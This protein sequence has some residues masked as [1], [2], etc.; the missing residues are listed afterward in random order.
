MDSAQLMKMNRRSGGS[1]ASNSSGF[2]L[3]DNDHNHNFDTISSVSRNSI[4]KQK[5]DLMFD[6]SRYVAHALSD[7][8]SMWPMYGQKERKKRCMERIRRQVGQRRIS[9][10]IP[11][12]PV[13]QLGKLVFELKMQVAIRSS[14]QGLFL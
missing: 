2:R 6:D 5:I 9:L 4:Y 14:I 12:S 1:M 13:T 8:E 7:T 11:G 10:G 3:L